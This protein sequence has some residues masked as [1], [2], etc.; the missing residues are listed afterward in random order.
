MSK[1][2]KKAKIERRKHPRSAKRAAGTSAAARSPA[3]DVRES[4]SSLQTAKEFCVACAKPLQSQD[5]ALFVEEEVGRIFC[6]EDCITNHFQSEI[7]GL[8]KEYLKARP[9]DDL[10]AEEREKYAH[11]RWVT[12]QE[13]D[14]VWRHRTP[15]GDSR[16]VLI[17]EFKPTSKPI[18]CVAICL[19]LRGEPSFL[20]LAFPTKSP[21][22][23]NRF[24]RG[25]RVEW[26]KPEKTENG[27]AARTEN[28]EAL[29]DRLAEDWTQNESVRAELNDI[30]S[31]D[32]IP[33]EEF[34]LYEHLMD[35]T[36]EE[37]DELW[38]METP[39]DGEP[40]QYHFIRYFEG[41]EGKTEGV[42]YVIVAQES[43]KEDQLEILDHF[44]TRHSETADRFRRGRQE[45]I[46]ANDEMGSK[47][48][49]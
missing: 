13:P 28:P 14:E 9:K 15:D 11:L 18:W 4:T 29:M 12:L 44:P 8:E 19:F 38:V 47:M 43:E 32:D 49:H 39:D 45:S 35:K 33:Q 1:N 23:V 30:R 40:D 34:P 17:S 7:E 10:S 41:E 16:Y 20:Y 6:S 3:S 22:L 27:D 31:P 37:P 2:A 36:L 26:V 48:I 5:R 46:E 21:A 25:E 24:R 42:F